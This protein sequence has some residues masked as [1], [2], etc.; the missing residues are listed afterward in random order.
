MNVRGRVLAITLRM[1]GNRGRRGR[2]VQIDAQTVEE[3]PA[4]EAGE[5]GLGNPCIVPFG[6]CHKPDDA[7]KR[8]QSIDGAVCGTP[9]GGERSGL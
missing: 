2:T 9:G 3:R 1:I 7:P 6:S 8:N 4:Y 5:N